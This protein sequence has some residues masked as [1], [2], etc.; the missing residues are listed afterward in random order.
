VKLKYLAGWT[1]RRIEIAS[2]YHKLLADVRGLELP[3]VREHVK[4]T[5]HHYVIRSGQRDALKL[6]LE[7]QGIQTA[8]HYPVS[9]PLLPVYNFLDNKSTFAVA[10]HVQTR[11]LS[12][13]MFSELTDAQVEYVCS[14]IRAFCSGSR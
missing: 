5:F 4:H 7:E 10:E 2:L 14:N 6:Y 8:I 13:P 12:L 9:L 3:K 1:D 11:I